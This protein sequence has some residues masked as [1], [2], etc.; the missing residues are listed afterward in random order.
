[1]EVRNDSFDRN[2]ATNTTKTAP[3]NQVY[4]EKKVATE[5]IEIDRI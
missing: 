1:M 4:V 2:K 5:K 3:Q